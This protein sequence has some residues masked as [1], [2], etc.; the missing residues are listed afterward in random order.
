MVDKIFVHNY[1][2]K[3][4]KWVIFFFQKLITSVISDRFSVNKGFFFFCSL[5]YYH[6]SKCILAVIGLCFCARALSSCGQQGLLCRVGFLRRWLLTVEHR[7]QDTEVSWGRS[8][9]WGLLA[10]RPQRVAGWCWEGQRGCGRLL[11]VHTGRHPWAL[12]GAQ[13]R[14]GTSR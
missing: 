10:L 8:T 11:G 12:S 9:P 4:N 3:S 1:V 5:F 2:K 6:F 13:P 7:L 14:M